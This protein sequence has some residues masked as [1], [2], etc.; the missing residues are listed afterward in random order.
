MITPT[1][2]LRPLT[3][4]L[5]ALALIVFGAPWSTSRVVSA[6]SQSLFLSVTDA[7]GEPVTDL[8][9]EELL[10]QWDGEDCE[11][12]DVEPINRELRNGAHTAVIDRW[13]Q[14]DSPSGARGTAAGGGRHESQRGDTGL[15]RGVGHRHRLQDHAAGARPGHRPEAS[16][17]EQPVSSDLRSA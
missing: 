3:G 14:P 2:R 12:L 5:L 10:V 17:G 8:T 16:S 6:Q 4:A 1:A 13:C 7:S 15:L 11:T 9:A